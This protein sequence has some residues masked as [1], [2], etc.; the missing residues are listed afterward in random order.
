ME[1]NST[2]Y[3]TVVD[4]E[5]TGGDE[6]KQ[7]GDTAEKNDEKFKSLR[8]QIRE[9]TV[10]LQKLAD[11]GK[12]GTD[13]FENLRKKLDDLNDAQ[14]KVAFQAGQFDDQLAALPGPLGA[15]GQ[16]IKSF[17][18]G[19]N[20]FST[21]FK[22]AFGVVGLI[23]SAFLALKESLSRTEEG[24]AKLTKITEAFTKIMNGLFAVI[25][26][27][28]MALADLAVKFLSNKSVME[29]ISKTIGVLAGVFT[30]LL[31]TL[32]QVSKFVG[33]VLIDNFKILI[34]VAKGAG[35]VLAGVFTFDFD[36][37]K[38][39]AN[40]AFKAVGDGV[41]NQL[42]NVKGLVKG[43]TTAVVDGYNA[44]EKGF[45]EGS[46]RLTELE[47]KNAEEA[48]KKREEAAAAAKAAAE[49]AL[50]DRL[51][52][53]DAIDKLDEARLDKEKQN[54]LSAQQLREQSLLKENQNQIALQQ[55]REQSLLK[56][57]KTDDERTKIT[58]DGIDERILIQSKSEEEK[59][60]ILL[61]GEEERIR[62]EQAFF[63]RSFALRKKDIED[64]RAL[65]PKS[66]NEYK[67]FTA[68]LI[69][70][71]SEYVK[72]SGDFTKQLGDN[73][74]KRIEAQKKALD[75][76]IADIGS[77]NDRVFEISQAMVRDESLRAET[78]RIN[79][80]NKDKEALQKDIEFLKNTEADKASIL[81][82]LEKG[83]QL[84]L[85][86]IKEEAR[87]KENEKIIK[88]Y[89]EQL[90][91][92]ELTGQSLIQGTKA[93]FE[94]RALVLDE[95][96]AR[97][98]AKLD[99][100]EKEKTAIKEK[101]VK[102]RKQLDEDE[103]QS[104]AAVASQTLSALSSVT[105]AL[106]SALD[107]EAKTSKEAFEKRKKLQKATA[108]LSAASGIIQIL[109]QPSTLPSPFDFI[110]KGINAAAL[111]IATAIQIK[112]INA[113]QFEGG[114]SSSS[115]S[116]PK[117][118][119]PSIPPIALP[120]IESKAAP[121][122]EGTQ[123]GQNP[124]R[125]LAETIANRTDR[126]VTTMEAGNNRMMSSMEA[127]KDRPIKTYVVSGD[128]TTQQALDRR[129]NRAATFSGGTV[130]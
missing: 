12:T 43:V 106:S 54:Q 60:E 34:G 86:K 40:D 7:L 6:L 122:V 128:V 38:K 75:K 121:V 37:I 65:Y 125:Q 97:E 27:I 84:D 45:K 101:Y 104:Y 74:Q 35:E 112:N 113:T 23:V 20:R 95:A 21:G 129:T 77:Y 53:L 19:L 56:E 29:G 89:D 8:G 123:G 1:S 16:G 14:E 66:S 9:T 124:T 119:T 41:K 24:Q 116:I 52:Y 59:T 47:K 63:Q 25:E 108:I 71:E 57:A 61:D 33:S 10:A 67:T 30:G 90:R 17:N 85:E 130:G 91:L 70:L 103:I 36:R 44:A 118:A 32:F 46:G 109:A 48:K 100:T 4:V 5:V 79:K 98:L 50:Q 102:L 3:T 83:L 55:L 26:P 107:E 18:E 31:G 87:V 127:N 120:T 58:Q 94:N 88:G 42:G 68:E 15:V 105:S 96:E 13:E 126:V 78:A 81:K 111:G 76:Q 92:L 73:Q 114:G 80:F 28:A 115:A 69:K 39:G 62:I 72:Q 64:K 51:K 2:T 93:Y 110:V 11:E 22:V 49:K 82:Q 117:S 99:I